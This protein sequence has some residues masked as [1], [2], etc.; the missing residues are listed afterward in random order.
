MGSTV[1]RLNPGDPDP[2]SLS[3]VAGLATFEAVASCLGDPASLMLK[4]PNDLLLKR[5][6]LAGILLE[7]VGDIV[8]V[9]VG[10][11]L[12]QAPDLPDRATMALADT[13][14]APDRDMF[15]ARLAAAFAAE[16]GLWRRFGV[17][18]L[19]RRWQAAAHPVGTPLAVH[20]PGAGPVSGT[21]DGLESDGALRLRLADGS[22]RA[23][24]AGDVTA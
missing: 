12:A 11:N 21:F 22:T 1:V 8:I 4:W 3:F 19:L 16:I 24:H 18:A 20:P 6:K 10:V 17:A 15:L 7:R 2:S 13:G 5:A 14:P 23:I 9:G